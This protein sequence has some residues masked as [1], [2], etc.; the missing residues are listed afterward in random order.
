MQD[1]T[2][3]GAIRTRYH[4]AT[5]FK[6]SRIS[7]TNGDKTIYHSYDHS[8]DQKENHYRA[9]QAFMDKAFLLRDDDTFIFQVDGSTGLVFGGDY[10]W[11]WDILEKKEEE[12]A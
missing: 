1:I 4:G 12:A 8:L 5:N 2:T 7:A 3:R 6:D 9:A 11:T 10:F